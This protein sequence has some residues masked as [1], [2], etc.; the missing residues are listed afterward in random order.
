[1]TLHH[2]RG[3][4]SQL[5]HILSRQLKQRLSSTEFGASLYQSFC[6]PKR[7]TRCSQ[8][9]I[10]HWQLYPCVPSPTLVAAFH[11]FL[12]V[13]HRSKFDRWKLPEKLPQIKHLFVPYL[14]RDQRTTPS[15]LLSSQRAFLFFSRHYVSLLWKKRLMR[16]WRNP[17]WLVV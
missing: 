9:S 16:S 13:L 8:T 14:L 10:L 7:N 17:L 5:T 6:N 2:A 11:T 3:T 12:W 15:R 4:W 1:M